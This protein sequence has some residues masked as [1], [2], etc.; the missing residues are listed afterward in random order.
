[1]LPQTLVLGYLQKH[2]FQSVFPYDNFQL[3]SNVRLEPLNFNTHSNTM[4]KKNTHTNKCIAGL[5]GCQRDMLRVLWKQWISSNNTTLNTFCAM[6]LYT[7]RTICKELKK[8]KNN[9]QIKHFVCTMLH[10]NYDTLKGKITYPHFYK[11]MIKLARDKTYLMCIQCFH[12]KR[13]EFLKQWPSQL[14]L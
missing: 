5:G 2:P 3:Y 1:M 8:K 6:N 12:K 10:R 13:M 7:S 9:T 4:G 14:M 11:C